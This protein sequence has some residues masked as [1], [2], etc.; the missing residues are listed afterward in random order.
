MSKEL[1]IDAF[2]QAGFSYEEIQDII[3]SEKEFKQS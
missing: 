3:E 2:K 1:D